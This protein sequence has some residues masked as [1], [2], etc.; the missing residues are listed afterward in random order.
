MLTLDIYN[1][2][3]TGVSPQIF[4][5]LLPAAFRYLKK[6]N[7]TLPSYSIRLELTLVS[8][9]TITSFNKKYH[10]KNQPTDVISLTY[11]EDLSPS[12][13]FAGEI[14][15]SL[16]YARRQ[17]QKIGQTLEEELRFLFIHG[18]LHIFG[19]DHKKPDE[20]EEMKALT[21]KIL[22]RRMKG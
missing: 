8:N 21:Y 22:G 4:Q 19:Y 14:F 17:A 2:T 13:P 6:E 15:I 10:N 18:L 20:E 16:S 12:D 9:E 3:K 5:S 11:L 7:S 1:K